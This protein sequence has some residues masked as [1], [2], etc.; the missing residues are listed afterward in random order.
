MKLERKQDV[1]AEEETSSEIKVSDE[2][3]AL[4]SARTNDLVGYPINAGVNS[5]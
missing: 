3:S 2:K 1:D 4:Q 5:L